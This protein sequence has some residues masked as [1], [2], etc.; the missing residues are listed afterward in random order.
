MAERTELETAVLGVV[1]QRGPCT[2]YV[3]RQ[4]FLRSPSSHWS[5]SAGAIYPL[6]RRLEQSGLIRSRKRAWG[7]GRKV[8]FSITERG[9]TTLRTWIGPPLPEWAGAPT[10]DP[11]RTRLS[12]LQ[13]LDPEGRCRFLDDAEAILTREIAALR[14]QART[15]DREAEPF[16]YLVLLGG[17]NEVEARRRWLREVRKALGC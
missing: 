9:L 16:E 14:A 10:M 15:F 12:F 8:E 17:L 3:V 7:S 4:E 13:L 11:V 6:L 2:A 1:W 5:G